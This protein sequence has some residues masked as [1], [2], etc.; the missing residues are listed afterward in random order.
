M[1]GV[2]VFTKM[3]VYHRYHGGTYILWELHYDFLRSVDQPLSFTIKA[4]RSGAGDWLDIGQVDDGYYYMVDP[5]RWVWAKDL[6][7]H[8][9]VQVTTGSGDTFQ[10]QVVQALGTL[11]QAAKLVA[12]EI[13]RKEQMLLEKKVGNLGLFYKRRHWGTKCPEC[14]DYDTGEVAANNCLIC[15]NTGFVGGYFDPIEVWVHLKVPSG[16]RMSQEEPTQTTENRS[17][18]GRMLA[19]PWPDTND[20]WV[21]CDNDQHF[22]VQ[23]VTPVEFRGVPILFDPVDLRLAQSSDIVYNLPRAGETSSSSG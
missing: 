9:M 7:I 3:D 5:N 8:Y 1:A 11:P 18:H 16:R 15:Y 17:K 6:R 2:K 23:K 12:R 20:V 14:V 21:N 13:M 19:C 22:V 4:S 10:S